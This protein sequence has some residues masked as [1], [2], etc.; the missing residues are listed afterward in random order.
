MSL[1]QHVE[2]TD[3]ECQA[4]AG[5]AFHMATMGQ[6]MLYVLS[7]CVMLPAMATWR[8]SSDLGQRTRSFEEVDGELP[9][10]GEESQVNYL[11]QLCSLIERALY[12]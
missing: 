10:D 3:V 4:L 9:D 7:Q 2:F 5:N 11:N 1:L 12:F 8:L 6:W